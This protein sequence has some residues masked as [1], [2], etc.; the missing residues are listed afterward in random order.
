MLHRGK[1]MAR[2]RLR[3]E[4]QASPGAEVVVGMDMA[5]GIARC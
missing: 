4:E 5:K 2:C 1:R 3:W